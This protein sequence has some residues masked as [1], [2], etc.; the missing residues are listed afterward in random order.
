VGGHALRA[1]WGNLIGEYFRSREGGRGRGRGGG[2]AE[3]K[4]DDGKFIFG[5]PGYFEVSAL[6]ALT[7]FFIQNPDVWIFPRK[8]ILPL[9]G[10]SGHLS[11]YLPP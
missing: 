11:F 5:G 4:R 9:S 3:G 10:Q 8:L 1:A 6:S 2:E 7:L